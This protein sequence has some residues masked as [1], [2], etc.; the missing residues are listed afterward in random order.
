MKIWVLV[1]T[2]SL[3]FV[4]R[5][6]RR[7]I[8]IVTTVPFLIS[9]I[10]IATSKNVET[11]YAARILAGM[12]A[13]LLDIMKN[14]NLNLLISG[15]TTVALIYVSEISHPQIR[16]VLLCLN[17]VFVSL[18]ILLTCILGLFFD[19]RTIAVIFGVLTVISCLLIFLIPESPRWLI[20][21]HPT[22]FERTNRSLQWI[23]RRYDVSIAFLSIF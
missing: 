18:G 13:G 10:L 17:S 1:V 19:W 16:P 4:Y 12:A 21:F 3:L 23:Y 22:D 14:T 9:W 2:D 20:T 15:L 8:A 7:P 11:I 5:F 6:G